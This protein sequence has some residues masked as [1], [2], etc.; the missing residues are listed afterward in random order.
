MPINIEFR[1]ASDK[2]LIKAD[3]VDKS[4][5]VLTVNVSII[6]C[7]FFWI[8]KIKFIDKKTRNYKKR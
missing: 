1:E 5:F 6:A 4:V 3:N 2:T 7:D 8:S